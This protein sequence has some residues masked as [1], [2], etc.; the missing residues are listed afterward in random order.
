LQHED[1]D[2]VAA[3]K[4]KRPRL[5]PTVVIDKFDLLMSDNFRKLSEIQSPSEW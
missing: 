4:R 5:T 3:V 2:D 1:A